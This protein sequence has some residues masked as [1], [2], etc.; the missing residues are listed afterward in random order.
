VL[1]AVAVE[2]Q[3]RRREGQAGLPVGAEHA[4]QRR[5]V[6]VHRHRRARPPL[7]AAGIADA[8]QPTAAA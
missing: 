2:G 3:H 1:V 5:H 4:R 8:L 7:A 6:R